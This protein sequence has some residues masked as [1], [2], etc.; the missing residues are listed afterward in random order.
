MGSHTSVA[1]SIVLPLGVRA[2]T[3][4]VAFFPI[5]SWDHELVRIRVGDGRICAEQYFGGRGWDCLDH[6]EEE[7]LLC[8]VLPSDVV[9]DTFALVI[10]ST[11]DESS[12]NEALGISRVDVSIPVAC[13]DARP[14]RSCGN[15][16]V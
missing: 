16:L 10:E 14:P 12:H 7:E 5:G 1:K 2:A 15:G 6:V 4:R 13:V 3:I 11:T 8:E 9:D